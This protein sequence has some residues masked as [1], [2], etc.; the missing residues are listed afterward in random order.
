MFNTAFT[1]NAANSLISE[2]TSLLGEASLRQRTRT[3]E[4]TARIETELANKV[5]SEF[6]S[7]MSHELR[8]PLN[9]VL[10][11]SKLLTDHNKRK[12]PD[13][14]IVDYATL[15]HDAA[16]HLLSVINDILDISKIQSGRYSLDTADVNIEEIIQSVISQ[17][18]LAA[19]EAN[20][21]VQSRIALNLPA[22]KGDTKKLRQVFINLV[23]N[24]IKFSNRGD[25][26][27]ISVAPSRER[28]CTVIVRDTGIGMTPEELQIAQTPFGQV[29]GGRD[30]MHEGTGLGLPIA[31]ALTE[32]HGGELRLASAKGK[33]TEAAV[34]LPPTHKLSIARARE[35]ISGRGLGS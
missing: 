6:I 3:A 34:L 29:D 4:Q 35:S 32:L 10:G 15:I 5:K 13:S 11:F 33:G 30:R 21:K 12:L 22:V 27:T 14:E 7:N 20:V 25:T 18:R 31:K 17:S 24:A 2:Y 16:S 26:V 1:K 8:T 23:S 28:G 19:A 9:T